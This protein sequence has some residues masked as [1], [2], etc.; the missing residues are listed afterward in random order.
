MSDDAHRGLTGGRSGLLASLGSGFAASTA[1]D[2]SSSFRNYPIDVLPGATYTASSSTLALTKPEGAPR[3]AELFASST[4]GVQCS[5]V[6]LVQADDAMQPPCR[7]SPACVEY[8]FTVS[9]AAEARRETYDPVGDRMNEHPAEILG[10]TDSL[11]HVSLEDQ[12]CGSTTLRTHHRGVAFSGDFETDLRSTSG[13]AALSE[14]ELEAF[15]EESNDL[16]ESETSPIVSMAENY[17]RETLTSDFT[18]PD[19]VKAP[20]WA[21]RLNRAWAVY[22]MV[23]EL[24]DFPD[25]VDTARQFGGSSL[26]LQ[27][28]QDDQG[29][30][31]ADFSVRV[32]AQ[33]DEPFTVEVTHDLGLRDPDELIVRAEEVPLD[34]EAPVAKFVR[35]LDPA[36]TFDITIPA[37]ETPTD[38]DDVAFPEVDVRTAGGDEAPPVV[39]SD[40][41]PEI[42]VDFTAETSS[43]HVPSP[44]QVDFLSRRWSVDGQSV[45]DGASTSVSLDD[46]GHSTIGLSLVE[47][48][49]SSPLDGGS[50]FSRFVGDE[51]I[52]ASN[53]ERTVYAGGEPHLAPSAQVSVSHERPVVGREVQ[54]DGSDSSAPQGIDGYEWSVLALAP[55]SDDLLDGE[56]VPV[57]PDPGAA[58]VTFTPEDPDRVYLVSL[59]V[60]G[61]DRSGSTQ[62]TVAPVPSTSATIERSP[63]SV[64]AGDTVRLDASPSS[65]GEQGIDEYAWT[66]ES[67]P[68]G[69][70]SRD[71]AREELSVAGLEETAVTFTADSANRTYHASLQIQAGDRTESTT[72][73]VTVAPGPTATIQSSSEQTA[74]GTVVTLDGTASSSPSGTLASYQWSIASAVDRDALDSA[75]SR[76]ETGPQVTFTAASDTVYGADLIVTGADGATDTTST[77]LD[78]ESSGGRFV[79]E[80][81]VVDGPLVAGESVTVEVLV[82]NEGDATDDRTV[83]LLVDG[84]QADATS[85]TIDSGSNQTVELSFQV[86]PDPDGSVDLTVET[87]DDAE[88]TTESVVADI[89][90]LDDGYVVQNVD[91]DGYYR[92]VNADGAVGQGDIAEFFS[93]QHR[94]AWKRPDLFDFSGNGAVTHGDVVELAEYVAL[95]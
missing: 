78:P 9:G 45:G 23:V 30:Y 5:N 83:R 76:T 84:E 70:G 21:K 62:A 74:D 68:E 55:D 25:K 85:P 87:D 69:S 1:A 86:G 38:I 66:V 50:W 39:V 64:V 57:E 27:A 61:G 17:L 82:A 89:V 67:V 24:L 77:V 42:G 35:R 71:Q 44:E 60:T 51:C 92:D 13:S 6:R 32:P 63:E 8:R 36:L 59:T 10:G 26:T 11:V 52:V 2:S 16:S 37:G 53:V 33:R 80:E 41:R 95:D 18:F 47:H 94:D 93:K 34:P 90:E 75:N 14:A 73:T 81:L 56:D 48:W 79:V 31:L 65:G 46:S 20:R 58:E 4:V 19:G 3:G 72:E 40:E 49:D 54:L 88:T 91:G 12:P 15:A 29:S 22:D 7:D 43:K 28:A